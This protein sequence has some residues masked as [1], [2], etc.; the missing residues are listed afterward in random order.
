MHYLQKELYQRVQSSPS[1]FDFILQASLDGVWYWDLEHPEHEWMNEDFWRLLGYD[2]AEK[3]H[4]A[5]EWQDL[6]HPDDLASAQANLEKH[7]ADPAYPYDQVVRYQHQS[8]ATVWVRCRGLAIRDA[9][10][11]PIRMLGAHNDL[12]ALKRSEQKLKQAE[13]FKSQFLANISHEL[14]T[15]LNGILGMTQLAQSESSAS[16]LQSHLGHIMDSGQ[17]LM[18]M[19]SDLL[20]FNKLEAGLVAMAPAPFALSALLDRLHATFVDTAK[21]KHLDWSVDWALEADAQWVG[22]ADLLFQLLKQLLSN[23]FKFTQS[24]R[25][26]L[27][28]A[29]QSAPTGD[30]SDTLVFSV[31]DTGVGMSSE[32]QAQLFQPLSQADSSHT[33]AFDGLGLGLVIG[34]RLLKLLGGDQMS[35]HSAPGEGSTFCFVLPMARVTPTSTPTTKRIL[36]VDDNAMQRVWLG[37]FLRQRGCDV[38]LAAQ[39]DEAEAWLKKKAFDW[40]VLDDFLYQSAH[41][42]WLSQWRTLCPNA[43]MILMGNAS[44]QAGHDSNAQVENAHFELDDWLLT[45]VVDTELDRLRQR[46]G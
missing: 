12:T 24:G 14:M 37:E 38:T 44:H 13:Q 46:W 32:M 41:P 8:G 34:D 36:L 15:P 19:V 29:T 6:I 25:V 10:G 31:T 1:V 2:P 9:S 4:L 35:V 40:V 5:S 17:H 27:R 20:F 11:R 26:R 7:L 45:P 30:D 39:L 22:D 33:R 16:A 18:T 28:V 42:P 23:A 21:A 43:V 3:Q